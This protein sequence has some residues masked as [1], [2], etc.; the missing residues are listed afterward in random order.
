MLQIRIT[1][2]D[3]H[4]IIL[5]FY[6]EQVLVKDD[7]TGTTRG[8]PWTE[9]TYST[10]ATQIATFY[11]LNISYELIGLLTAGYLAIKALC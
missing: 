5:D 9:Y 2:K 1:R 6:P 7:T 10:L 3:G 4:V 8:F 11:E